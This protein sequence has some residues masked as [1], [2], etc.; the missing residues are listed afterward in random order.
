MQKIVFASIFLPRSV[1]CHHD[2]TSQWPLPQGMPGT[3]THSQ[4][5]FPLG[6]SLKLTHPVPVCPGTWH[7]WWAHTVSQSARPQGKS[8]EGSHHCL[9]LSPPL[10]Q[11]SRFHSFQISPSLHPCHHTSREDSGIALGS[12]CSRISALVWPL[13]LMLSWHLKWNLCLL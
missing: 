9:N 6:K 11:A 5:A 7:V 10:G 1:S 8:G 3:H 4:S 2:I 12:F 13:S